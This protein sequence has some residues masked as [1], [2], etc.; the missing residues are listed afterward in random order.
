MSVI[1]GTCVSIGQSGILIR[2]RSGAGKSALV[3]DDC[4]EVEKSDGVLFLHAPAT[5]AGQM[6]VRGV[7]ILRTAHAHRAR[8]DLIVDLA[9]AGQIE[10][11]PEKTSEDI[12]GIQVAWMQVDPREASADAKVRVVAR[13]LTGDVII[14]AEKGVPHG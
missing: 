13:A 6:E 3:A 14:D 10:R 1:H 4:C 7:G 12:E 11:L 2:G 8:L 9:D 5:I